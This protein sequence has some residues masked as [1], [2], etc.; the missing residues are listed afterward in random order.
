MHLILGSSSNR[1]KKPLRLA[2]GRPA[3]FGPPL[4]LHNLNKIVI[5]ACVFRIKLL[6]RLGGGKGAVQRRICMREEENPWRMAELGFFK[7]ELWREVAMTN[8]AE[9]HKWFSC[10]VKAVSGF[11]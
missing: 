11:V 8:F 5:Q 1:E 3:I 6:Q 7:I 4:N 2:V 9:N 10:T